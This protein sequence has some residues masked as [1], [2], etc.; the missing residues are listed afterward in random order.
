MAFLTLPEDE[1][2]KLIVNGEELKRAYSIAFPDAIIGLTDEEIIYE[3]RKLARTKRISKRRAEILQEARDQ[4]RGD[5]QWKF[6]NSVTTLEYVIN[7]I[8]EEIE[9]VESAHYE[10]LE[11]LQFLMDM[12]QDERKKEKLYERLLKKQ[13]WKHLTQAQLQNMTMAVSELNDMHGF[14]EEN[15]NLNAPIIF[16]GEEELED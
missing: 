15:I 5:R 10:E 8:T 13:Q 9:N 1:F 2:A 4:L 7:K 11:Y 16:V 14:N 12:E 3:A 6:D